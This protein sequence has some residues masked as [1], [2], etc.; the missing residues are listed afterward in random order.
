MLEFGPGE[1]RKE[2]RVPLLRAQGSGEAFALIVELGDE[3]VREEVVL[4]SDDTGTRARLGRSVAVHIVEAVSERMEGSLVGCMPRPFPGQRV[5]ASHLLSG[6]GMQASGERPSVWGCGAYSRLQSGGV[7]GA[8]GDGVIGGGLPCGRSLADG[9]GGIAQRG[10]GAGRDATTDDGLVSVRTL[11]GD[12][13]HY[14]G[15]GRS[16]TGSSGGSR[17]HG[18]AHDGSGSGRHVG[19]PGARLG[20]QADGFWLGMEGGIGV[21]RVRA[22]LEGS[23]TLQDIIEPYVEAAVLHSGGDAEKGTGM[24]AGGGLRVRMGML[25]AEVML[26]RLVMHQE[27]G[28]GEWGYSGTVRYGGMEGLGAQVR[29]TWGRTHVG[30]LWQAERPWEVYPSDRRMELEVEVETARVFTG[31]VYCG[32][33]WVWVCATEAGTTA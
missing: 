15:V 20:Y 13:A 7:S 28:Y 30:T 27:D 23:V 29:P 31:A 12:A 22:G 32:R 17:G 2:V 26:R 25:H 21:S 1:I 10:I 19:T 8:D 14:V 24:E 16:R 5:R 9:D 11:R 4:G 6:C 18:N 3:T 33:M